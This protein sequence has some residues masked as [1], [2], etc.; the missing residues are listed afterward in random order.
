MTGPYGSGKLPN[1]LHHVHNLLIEER[2]HVIG[3]S[4]TWLTSAVDDS[5]VALSNYRIERKDN[6]SYLD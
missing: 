3:V 2:L 6:P 5:F 4:E 1:K